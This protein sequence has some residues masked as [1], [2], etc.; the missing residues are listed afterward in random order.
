MAPNTILKRLLDA[1]MQFTEMSQNTAEKLVG[2]FVQAGQVRRKD[3][4]RTVQRL[5]DRGRSST[6]QLARSIQ[7]VGLR[8]SS[9]G[10][11]PHQEMEADH[12]PRW[13]EGAH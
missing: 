8:P 1:G 11:A 4:E 6:E 12:D 2:E 3:A 13:G 10:P 7:K 5:V 9:Q